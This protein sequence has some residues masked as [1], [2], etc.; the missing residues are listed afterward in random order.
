[1]MKQVQKNKEAVRMTILIFTLLKRTVQLIWTEAVS[2][3]LEERNW[4]A[5]HTITLLLTT[6]LD[7]LKFFKQKFY[8]NLCLNSI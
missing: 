7:F 3:K 6:K 1:M 5:V 2:R 4:S 8:F